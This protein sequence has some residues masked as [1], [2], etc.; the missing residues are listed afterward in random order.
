M[1]KHEFDMLKKDK[2]AILV[3]LILLGVVLF[4]LYRQYVAE[5][6]DMGFMG[7]WDY[8]A[9]WI[10]WLD[11]PA[12]ASFLSSSL[13]GHISQMLY[14]W[15]LPV[16]LLLI[17]C[18]KSIAESRSGYFAVMMIKQG[19]KKFLKT[20]FQFSF[21]MGFAVVFFTLFL[22]Y[23]LAI[24][25]F[26]GGP[27]FDGLELAYFPTHVVFTFSM[28]YPYV[29]YFLYI[30]AVSILSGGCAMICTGLSFIFTQYRYLYLASFL[31]WYMQIIAPNS[32][33]YVMQPFIEYDL[34]YMLPALGVFAVICVVAVS[35]GYVYRM[36]KD[37]L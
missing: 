14:L 29:A 11:H 34:P 3:F 26:W 22:N 12:N 4:D 8:P 6:I 21:L 2:K 15:I 28:K 20:K 5:F 27:D 7:R 33:T 36:R 9:K 17:Y 19:K 31:L 30:I 37:E 16:Y 25:F 1:L 24:V 18:D 10:K 13:E 35:A 32:L 23:I